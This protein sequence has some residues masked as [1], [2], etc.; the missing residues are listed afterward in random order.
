MVIKV[1]FGLKNYDSW[2]KA[3]VITNTV[4]HSHTPTW[5]A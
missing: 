1:P 2:Y 3:L 5:F 4:V